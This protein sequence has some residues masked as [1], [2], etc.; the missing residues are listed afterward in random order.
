MSLAGE[1]DL[2]GVLGGSR[3]R[4]FEVS[5]SSGLALAQLKLSGGTAESGGAIFSNAA[6]ISKDGCVLERN[7]ASD[8]NG[9]AVWAKGGELTIVGVGFVGN[10]ASGNAGA[11]W[12]SEVG[13]VVQGGTRFESNTAATKGGGLYFDV[14]EEATEAT[15][16][17]AVSTCSV[18]R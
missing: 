12:A 11:V 1:D 13:L 18:L 10:S 15:S 6:S 14:T 2:T 5:D 16:G 4:L 8:G 7:S 9:G 17:A 3:V